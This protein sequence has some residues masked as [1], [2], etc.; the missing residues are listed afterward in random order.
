MKIAEHTHARTHART[1]TH[2]GTHSHRQSTDTDARTRNTDTHLTKRTDCRTSQKPQI[3]QTHTQTQPHPST[4]RHHAG[5]FPHHS[6]Q[7]NNLQLQ[8]STTHRGPTCRSIQRAD[9]NQQTNMSRHSRFPGVLVGVVLG[10]E[11]V[12]ETLLRRCGRPTHWYR[13]RFSRVRFRQNKSTSA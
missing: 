5:T 13:G 9:Q 10:T 3:E 8:R 11:G 2:S 6:T 7:S 4:T 1:R 12:G